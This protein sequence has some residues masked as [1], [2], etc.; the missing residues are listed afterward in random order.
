MRPEETIRSEKE[1]NP[2]AALDRA[3]TEALE[4]RPEIAVPA[5]FAARL[6]GRLADERPGGS[7]R[8][9]RRV[10]VGRTVGYVSAAATTVALA[11]VAIA[12][13]GALEAGKTIAFGLE[14]LLVA[15]L[16]GVGLWLGTRRDA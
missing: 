10:S 9:R 14:M 4:Q 1:S 3:L 12:N 2:A 13:P 7:Y 8:T 5:G 15:E 6:M 11:A 16:L